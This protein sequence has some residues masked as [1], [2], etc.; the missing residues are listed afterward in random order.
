LQR[1]QITP[2]RTDRHV[3]PTYYD[4]YQYFT[5]NPSVDGTSLTVSNRLIPRSL[6]QPDRLPTLID[7]IRDI[8]T[9]GSNNSAVFVI[10]NN[11][12]TH[13]HVGNRPGA[14]AVLPA[15]RNSLFLL[16]FG[17][18]LLPE[19]N[20]PWSQIRAHQVLV[21]SWLDAFRRLTPG[22]GSYLNEGTFDYPSWKTEYYG[23]NYGRLAAIE[24]KYDPEYLFF[25]NAAVGS[26]VVWRAGPDGSGR[27]CRR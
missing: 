24:A 23:A 7:T 3:S 8:A 5:T 15:W 14:N 2:L 9:T 18:Q 25:A 6:A 11:N 1:L 20:A 22:G 10:I 19:G 26:D 16:N 27:L 13:A 17:L 12:V 21:N 4:H